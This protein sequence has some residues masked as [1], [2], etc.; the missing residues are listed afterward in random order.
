LANKSSG[1]LTLTLPTT[2]AVGKIIRVSGIQNTWRIAQNA[3][4]K[5]HFGNI[6][7]TTG[8]GGYLENTHA[9]DSVE[10]VCCVA[11]LEWNVIS[12]IGNITIV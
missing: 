5:I 7:T 1:T 9:R 10:I 12:S 8:V 2:A 4:Q 11:D 3:S 6:T